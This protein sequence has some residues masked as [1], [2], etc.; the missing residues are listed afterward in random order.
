DPEGGGRAWHL[1]SIEPADYLEAT[2]ARAAAGAT[3]PSLAA[4]LA[5]GD[6]EVSAG[7]AE[8][9]VDAL[10]D[11]Q[12]LVPD[13]APAITGGEPLGPLA[14]RSAAPRWRRS[15]AAWSCCAASAQR[16][17]TRSRSS[18]PRS[19]PA[20]RSARSRL[21]RRST[22]SAAS[23]SRCSAPRRASR[24]RWWRSCGSP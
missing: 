10:I 24:R 18:A 19:P 2:L 8:A 17:T 13:A 16:R 7:E 9:Y 20:T 22:R 12:V 3:P 5:A 15:R 6:A 4:A 11:A 21:S 14:A 1:V 23:A